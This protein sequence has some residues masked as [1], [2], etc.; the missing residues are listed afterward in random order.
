M[1]NSDSGSDAG[2]VFTA[3]TADGECD[4]DNFSSVLLFN[5]Y[6]QVYS[7]EISLTWLFRY[8]VSLNLSVQSNFTSSINVLFGLVKSDVTSV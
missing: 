2:I 8:H 3:D 4:D 7:Q 5:S 6:S 1:D